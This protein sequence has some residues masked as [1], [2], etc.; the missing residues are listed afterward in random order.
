MIA[1]SIQLDVAFHVGRTGAASAA[2]IGGRIGHAPRGIEPLLQTL[3]RAELLESVRGPHGGYRLGR[4]ARDI[5]LLEIVDAAMS[6]DEPSGRLSGRLQT[7]V[8]GS[9][10]DELDAAARSLLASLT[11]DD[12]LR[13]AARAGLH[14][15]TAEP[16]DFTI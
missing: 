12:L 1:I 10:W 2:E 13:R 15:R 5:V 7:L 16:I 11:L 6:N 3:T 8:V 9:L 14:R 4:S